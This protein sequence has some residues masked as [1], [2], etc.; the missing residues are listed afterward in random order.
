MIINPELMIARGYVKSPDL[1]L[2]LESQLQPNGIDVRIRTAYRIPSSET[3]YLPGKKPHQIRVI[4]DTEHILHLFARTAY[5]L[6]CFEHVE[7]PHNTVAYIYGR[8]TLNRNGIYARSSLYDSGFKNFV[9]LTLYPFC[10]MSVRIGERIAQIV[11]TKAEQS[12]VYNGQ[13][14]KDGG[15]GMR[16]I[17]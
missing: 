10:N 13:Y 5:N 12:G 17:K 14:Q 11:F 7:I 4:P 9:G 8:S 2:D 3:L 15:Y 6:E 16:E 1:P